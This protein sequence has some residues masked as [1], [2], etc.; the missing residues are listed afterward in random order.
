MA[1]DANDLS[2]HEHHVVNQTRE[3]EVADFSALAGGDGAKPV[4]RAGFLRKL[5][6]RLDP[7]WPVQ[8]PGVRIKG[9]RIEG[10][11][12]LR[13]CAGGAG[14]PALALVECEIPVAVNLSHTRLARLS[15]EGSRLRFLIAR[16]T[17]ID[18]EFCFANVAPLAE[19]GDEALY[20][21]MR[22]AHIGGDVLG[23][24]ARLVRSANAGFSDARAIVLFMQGA[25]IGGNV[26]LGEKF[27]ATGAISLAG[28]EIG[29]ALDLSQASLANRDDPE[30]EDAVLLASTLRVRGTIFLL[31]G[32][33][34]DGRI[35]LEGAAIGGGVLIQDAAIK[36]EASTALNLAN[37]E[38]QNDLYLGGKITGPVSL[39]GAQIKRNV[40]FLDL[41]VAQS[42]RSDAPWQ[43][44]TA[45]DLRVGGAMRLNGANIKGETNLSDARIDG[46]L[47]LGGARFINNGGWALRASNIRVGGNLLLRIEDGEHAPFGNKTV[48]EG[49]ASFERGRI[50]GALAWQNLEIRGKGAGGQGASFSIADATIAGPIEARA[51]TTQQDALID[52]SGA[53]CAALDDDVKT[54][55]GADG[56]RLN[57]EGFTYGRLDGGAESWRARLGWL[58][59]A[60]GD[61]GRH[62]PQPF[63]QAAQVYARAGKREAARR[64]LLA[65]H[66]LRSVSG[67]QGPITWLL[68]S[69]FGLIA[70]YGLAPIRVV[71]ALALYLAIG[72]AGVL[73]MNAQ[74]ALVTPEG[75]QCNG[76]IEPA[77]YA[78]DV[79]LP[80]IDLGQQ[81]AC[82]PGR[83]ARAELST[84][85][86]VSANSDWRLFEGLALWRWAHGLYAIFG[87]I[88]AALAVL[89]FSGV[90]KPR[91]N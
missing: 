11:L 7:D 73:A 32:F 39:R 42:G 10:A 85:V 23:Y 22:A 24:G 30:T 52:A 6:L 60:R 78:I 33:K 61:E 2:P 48:I 80:L 58:K 3:G 50:E 59:R 75:R 43:A 51:F 89:T 31:D 55:W 14:L 63:A 71:R 91:D 19:D 79:A 35:N 62:S 82:G 87:A 77:L 34:A 72:V 69:L 25:R 44:M 12:D 74:G 8:A 57:L 4:I 45:S 90:M 16:E 56:A 64:I 5:L 67:A 88:L 84:G 36:H 9:A 26:M 15:I 53:T 13:D 17:R 86:E 29:G 18:G 70:G 37:A 27:S 38:V 47:A 49:A 54:G 65:Q 76:A 41:E 28:A 83:T 46:M 21:R 40:S 68:S 81:S 66:D 1:F 20:L